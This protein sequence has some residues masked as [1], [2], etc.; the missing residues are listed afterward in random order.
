MEAT[1][2]ESH[3]LFGGVEQTVVQ[4]S[5]RHIVDPTFAAEQTITTRVPN[6]NQPAKPAFTPPVPQ[7]Q[8]FNTMLDV[9]ATQEFNVSDIMSS[10]QAHDDQNS[11]IVSGDDVANKLD[12]L[13]G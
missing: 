10:A 9:E 6:Y 3:A 5:P 4:Q 12:A 11:G 2:A 13:F 8:Q 1:A 7:A